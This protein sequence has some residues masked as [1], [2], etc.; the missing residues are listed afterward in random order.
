LNEKGTRHSEIK[1]HCQYNCLY[2]M[3]FLEIRVPEIWIVNIYFDGRSLLE[4]RKIY[5]RNDDRTW[6]IAGAPGA[7]VLYCTL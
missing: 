4:W 1:R 3:F 2:S 5:I 7:R 6:L